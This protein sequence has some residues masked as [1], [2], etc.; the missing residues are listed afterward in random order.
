MNKHLHHTEE[1]QRF[2]IIRAP[3]SIETGELTPTLKIRRQ[4]VEQKFRK[5][6]DE[7][8]QN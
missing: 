1:V 2:S 4:V 6:I 3:I 5:E 8:Y 7:M